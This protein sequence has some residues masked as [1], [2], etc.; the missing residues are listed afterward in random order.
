MMMNYDNQT[1]KAMEFFLSFDQGK[2]TEALKL[3]SDELFIY[4][5]FIDRIYAVKRDSGRIIVDGEEA[6][7]DE[8]MSILDIICSNMT[9]PDS[10]SKAEWASLSQIGGASARV[11]MGAIAKRLD[12]FE[13]DTL[14]MAKACENIGG[15]VRKG[16][17]VSYVISVYEGIPCWLQYWEADDEYPASLNFL[18]D[19]DV[20][21]YVHWATLENIMNAVCDRLASMA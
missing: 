8:I 1:L 5:K 19:K 11:N 15:R 17:D 14:A 10:V 4:V 20:L 3:D 7:C 6:T 16:G 9:I 21:K 12:P 2:M 18:F 13:G